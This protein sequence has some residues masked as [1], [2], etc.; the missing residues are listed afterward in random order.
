V[1]GSGLVCHTVNLDWS[2]EQRAGLTIKQGRPPFGVEMKI[3]DVNNLPLPH[4]GVAFGQLK[5]RGPWVASAYF[6]VESGPA[7]DEPGWFETGDVATIDADGFMHIVDRSKD[8]IKSG[9][10]WISSI[11]LELIAIGHPA[12]RE[13][14]A[15]ARPDPKWGERP[16]LVVALKPEASV[17]ATEMRAFFESHLA[18]WQVPDDIVIVD[19]L[20]HTATGKLLKF[21]LR[22]RYGGEFAEGAMKI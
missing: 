17:T 9:G 19:D 12:V 4:D 2:A 5:V 3:V 16:R 18:K 8:V 11:T 15:I 14:A 7:H 13:A 6:G 20:P 21:E 1:S 10:E 22:R